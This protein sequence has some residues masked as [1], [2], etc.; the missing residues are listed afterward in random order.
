MSA[1]H[2]SRTCCAALRASR[3]RSARY[4]RSRASGCSDTAA[5]W[6][7]SCRKEISARARAVSKASRR[8][9]GSSS[10]ELWVRGGGGGG[11]ERRVSP[12]EVNEV[13]L[14]DFSTDAYLFA[15]ASSA[16]PFAASPGRSQPAVVRRQSRVS[17][18]PAAPGAPAVGTRADADAPRARLA[19]RGCIA[20]GA[21]ARGG[22]AGAGA[23]GTPRRRRREG[24]QAAPAGRP[25]L[26]PR[27]CLAG[28]LRRAASRRPSVAPPRVVAEMFVCAG[29]R[30]SKTDWPL[31]GPAS[32]GGGGETDHGR[33]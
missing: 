17:A 8:G 6:L 14:D 29:R 21:R 24:L 3:R 19:P 22:R 30:K 32:S 12:G 7:S 4:R 2:G 16:A 5:A 10:W 18:P 11:G 31:E 26:A 13:K 15:A 27:L 20:S 9:A 23:R 25:R 1:H 28:A 33:R